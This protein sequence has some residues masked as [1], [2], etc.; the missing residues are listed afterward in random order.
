MMKDA[1]CKG[2]ETEGLCV[3]SIIENCVPATE[4]RRMQVAELAYE[5]CDRWFD[6]AGLWKCSSPEPDLR[7]TLW[8]CFGLLAGKEAAVN[9]ANNILSH[10]EFSHHHP[11][12]T[13]EEEAARFDI[14]VTNHSVQMLATCAD[15]LSDSVREKLESWAR[16]ALKDYAGDRQSDY[17]FH[18]ANDNM[19]AKATLGMILGGEYFGDMEAVQHGLWNLR[20]LRDL[21]TRRGLISEYTSPT[22]SPLSIINL[23]EIALHSRNAEARDLAEQCAER[24]W[25]DVLGHFHPPTGMMGGPYSRAY[26]LD[27]T[28]HFSTVACLLWI[29]LG[30]RISF[31]PTAELR[32][33]PIRLVHHHDDRLT[34]LGIL[35]WIA[36]CPAEPPKYLTQWLN[37]RKYPFRLKASAERGGDG[38]GEVDTTFY[39]E[40]DFALG[41]VEGESWCELQSETFFLQF[42][43]H[44]PLR[45]IED[46]RTAY[47]RYLI[48][49]QRPGDR[50]EDQ[51]L[52]PHGIIHTV[53][54]G[55]TALVL[56]RP[57]LSLADSDV[58]ALKFSVIVPA[59]FGKLG[60]IEIEN[61]DVFIEDGPLYVGFRGL[62]VTDWGRGESVRIETYPNY[63]VLSFFN[64]EGG[65]RRFSDDELGR[66]LNG[67]VAVV[68][69]KAEETSDAFRERIKAAEVL[70]YFHCGSRVVRCRVGETLLGMSYAVNADRVRYA[71]INGK[72]AERPAW[73]AD[74]LPAGRL[75]FLEH[76]QP[77]D[78]HFPYK[79]LRA[80]WA[81]DAPWVIGSRGTVTDNAAISIE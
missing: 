58:Q 7:K 13:P 49:D 81:P 25:A 32:R 24:I 57:S 67:F 65:N 5:L 35:T 61:N 44:A 3:S 37:N 66:T 68:G 64:Y 79:H 12:R 75:P 50:L 51:Y 69:L 27:S 31:D 39:A 71:S 76:P 46:V 74:G 59:H 14:F 29:V 1:P 21:L 72:S 22:Y 55:R 45:G 40:E 16:P 9:L 30:E 17:Q 28:G 8:L 26:Q 48:N 70:D 53:H 19:P 47:C 36:S 6:A 41:T 73:K 60:R 42:R 38:A 33:E 78:F 20:Q 4:Q 63:Q 52:K 54:E 56:A 11:T 18:G 10:R 62:N 80:V 23:T 77:N 34:Q 2:S 43:S 15:R